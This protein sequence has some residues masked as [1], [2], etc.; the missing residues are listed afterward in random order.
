M[1]V[2]SSLHIKAEMFKLTYT[3]DKFRLEDKADAYEALD[4]MIRL[5]HAW[6]LPARESDRD[7]NEILRTA[8]SPQDYCFAH[9]GFSQ[10]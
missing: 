5:L 3:E 7:V 9:E 1:R 8:C 4:L 6:S 10:E 2:H